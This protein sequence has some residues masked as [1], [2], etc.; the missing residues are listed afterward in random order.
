MGS[1][2]SYAYLSKTHFSWPPPTSQV[3]LLKITQILQSTFNWET[4]VTHEPMMAT[5]DS[6]RNPMFITELLI[7]FIKIPVDFSCS[8]I[9][10]WLGV[11]LPYNLHALGIAYK[12]K[13]KIYIPLCCY[14]FPKSLPLMG[15]QGKGG[16][17]CKFLKVWAWICVALGSV[18]G[19]DSTL[20]EE[21]PSFEQ[22][23]TRIIYEFP[24]F[25]FLFIS[26]FTLSGSLQPKCG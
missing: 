1:R 3:H 22:A 12:M 23:S 5:P 7:L 17:Y 16:I 6:K 21:P 10:P 4:R 19:T 24:L 2:K 15:V 20:S 14:L 26:S 11:I 25:L 18:V 13:V 9:F 8:W